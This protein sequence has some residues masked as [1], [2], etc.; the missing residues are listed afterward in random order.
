L[1]ALLFVHASCPKYAF[2]R[3]IV[4][5]VPCLQP[6]AE[7]ESITSAIAV[8]ICGSIAVEKY[9]FLSQRFD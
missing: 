7:K 9:S 5:A 2:H 1:A 3:L 4:I 6:D 8:F